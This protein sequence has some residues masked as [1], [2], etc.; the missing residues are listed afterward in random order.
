MVTPVPQ[1]LAKLDGGLLV[2]WFVA[3]AAAAGDG[4]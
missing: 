4:V 1:T 2:A 3:D